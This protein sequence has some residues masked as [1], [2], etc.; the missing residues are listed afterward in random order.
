MFG[1]ETKVTFS[2]CL[3]PYFSTKKKV[4][5]FLFLWVM[6]LFAHHKEI[7]KGS[8]VKKDTLP[9]LLPCLLRLRCYLPQ[10][11]KAWGGRGREEE[12]DEKR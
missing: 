9:L 12:K 4:F 3:C 6:F 2:L 1:T 11:E 8:S 10:K 7:R 5:F